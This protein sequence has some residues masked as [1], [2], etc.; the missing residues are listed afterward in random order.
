MFNSMKLAINLVLVLI[1]LGLVYLLVDSIR[2]PIEFQDEKERRSTVVIDKLKEIRDAQR[3]HRD[4]KGVFANDF[5]SLIHVLRTDSFNRIALIGDPDDATGEAYIRDTTRISAYDSIRAMGWDLDN[6][7]YVPFTD[8][9]RFFVNADT[10]TYQQTLTA[11]VEVGV[12]WKE[13]MG[14]Y[15][16]PSYRK[17]DY[18]YNPEGV[19]RF[20]SMS[21]PNLSG[22]WE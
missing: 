5:D 1:V 9:G 15:A 13:F 21:N 3:M 6:L 7:P 10:I 18:R 2:E 12:K 16:D 8:G 11:V 4:I 19:L 17:Y 20:G 14:P 22:N